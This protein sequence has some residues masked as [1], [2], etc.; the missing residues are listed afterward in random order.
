VADSERGRGSLRRGTLFGCLLDGAEDV[1]DLALEG[2]EIEIDDAAARMEDY[3]DGCAEGG[4]VF[5]DGFAHTA[6]DAIAIDGFAQDL[7]D[8]EADAWGGDAGIAK[9]GAIW[10]KLRA[11]AEEKAHLLCKLLA[12]GFV[13]AL[14]VGVFAKT[15]DRVGGGGHGLR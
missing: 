2:G 4:E 9:W 6:L 1:G 10:P 15:E 5:A 13:D 3:V 8:G 7:A 11:E 14:I 12:A